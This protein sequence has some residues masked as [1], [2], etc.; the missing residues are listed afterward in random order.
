MAVPRTR[1]VPLFLSQQTQGKMTAA[2][3]CKPSTQKIK[4]V[5]SKLRLI[6]GTLP[7]P[8]VAAGEEDPYLV[9]GAMS[10]N[11]DSTDNVEAVSEIGRRSVDYAPGTVTSQ[12]TMVLF[13]QKAYATTVVG[14]LMSLNF[15]DEGER[16][17]AECHYT[18]GRFLTAPLLIT[19]R[20]DNV[21]PQNVNQ[22]NFNF[23]CTDLPNYKELAIQAEPPYAPENLVATHGATAAKKNQITLKFEES[24]TALEDFPPTGY[25]LRSRINNHGRVIRSPW[26]ELDVSIGATASNGMITV[27]NLLADKIF[28]GHDN[29]RPKPAAV[30]STAEIQAAATYNGDCPRWSKSLF[31]PR[32]PKFTMTRAAGK[33]TITVTEDPPVPSG[34]DTEVEY[35]AAAA[36]NGAALASANLAALPANGEV[37]LSGSSAGVAA[38]AAK[39]TDADGVARYSFLSIADTPSA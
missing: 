17:Y 3:A 36:A 7:P 35:V 30:N 32:A 13:Y 37:T 24:A 12:G 25:K 22:V 38:V 21:N 9:E 1:A 11:V 6:R 15:V 28:E 31:I 2:D 34:W 10:F 5:V 27:S 18:D 39:F 16:F 19:N 20:S 8:T 14:E 26:K 33:V 4:G 29:I 23:V